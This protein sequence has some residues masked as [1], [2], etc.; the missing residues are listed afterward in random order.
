MGGIEIAG[1]PRFGQLRTFEDLIKERGVQRATVDIFF[2]RDVTKEE[3]EAA[4][5]RIPEGMITHALLVELYAMAKSMHNDW[6][7]MKEQ[8]YGQGDTTN[9]SG[10]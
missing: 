3:V 2:G 9:R 10:D 6:Q 1:P 7:M 8:M 4:M 5:P